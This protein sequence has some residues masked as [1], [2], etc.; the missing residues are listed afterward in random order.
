[1]WVYICFKI[2]FG[3]SGEQPIPFKI[4]LCTEGFFIFAEIFHTWKQNTFIKIGRMCKVYIHNSEN[5]YFE[6][7]EKTA[8]SLLILAMFSLNILS[9]T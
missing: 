8:F 4:V 6:I 9:L 5:S 2:V 3:H 7:K 1:M